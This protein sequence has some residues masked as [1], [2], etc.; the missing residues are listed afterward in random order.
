MHKARR[1]ILASVP[2]LAMGCSTYKPSEQPASTAL[3][4]IAFGSCNDQNRPQT[5]WPIIEATKPDLFIFGGDNVYASG[6][7]FQIQ[8]LT[9]AYSKL[10]AD[11]SFSEFRKRVPHL[12]IWD[13][14][15]YCINDGGAQWPYK[16]AAKDEFLKFWNIGIADARHQ[17]EGLYFAE[18][19][20]A[21]NHR[22]QIIFLD[23]RWWRS[24][25]RITDQ[26]NAPGKERYLP[27]PDPAKT[28][29]GEAQWQWLEEQLNQPAKIRLIVSS[30]QTITLGHGWESWALLPLEKTRLFNTV[31]RTKA[32]GVIFLSGDRHIGALYKET[33]ATPYPFYEMTSSGLTH[34]WAQANEAGPNRLGALVTKNHFGL[35]DFNWSNDTLTLSL[36]TEDGQKS[37]SHT[38]SIKEL[39]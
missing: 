12:A 17:H 29:L 2:S 1:N 16:Q 15:D 5:I 25:W 37:Q 28:M 31:A 13:D 27:D 19:F 23:T 8:D 9:K 6:A 7:Q 11:T 18:T 22:V 26:R 10:A 24:P 34:A 35:C 21:S 39:A 3:T 36:V 14:H 33:S 30:I 38:I 20:G 32:K 4:R